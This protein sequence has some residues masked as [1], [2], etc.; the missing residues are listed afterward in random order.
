MICPYC[1]EHLEMYERFWDYDD[2]E[3]LS[4]VEHYHCVHCDRTF[5]REVTYAITSEGDLTE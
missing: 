5:Y 1:G 3:I 4:G 2:G